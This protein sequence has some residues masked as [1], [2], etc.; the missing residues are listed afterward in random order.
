LSEA[1]PT[2]AEGGNTRPGKGRFAVPGRPSFPGGNANRKPYR[3]GEFSLTEAEIVRLFASARSYGD[4]VL[5][6]LA[7]GTGIRREDV[8][9]IERTGFDSGAGSITYHEAKKRRVRTVRIGGET[10][11]VLRKW[12]NELPA[13]GRWLFPS[14]ER[15]SGHLSGRT[16]Y[17]VLQRALEAA[18][19]EGRPF[20]ALRST[21]VKR[22]QRAGWTPEQV[23]EL[24]GDSIRVIQ[25]HYATPTPGEMAEVAKDRPL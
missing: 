8:V 23:S 4:E 15:G 1:V 5:L 17:N 10:L 2:S 25:L 14:R 13:S 7:I 22:A 18:G 11:D 20:H 9:R 6:R 12:T 16:A 21:C 19:L 24:T 3:T